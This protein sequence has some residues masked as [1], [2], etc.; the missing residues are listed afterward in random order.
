MIALLI[1][2]EIYHYHKYNHK[3]MTMNSINMRKPNNNFLKERQRVVNTINSTICQ[4]ANNRSVNNKLCFPLTIIHRTRLSTS[5][6]TSNNS[7]SKM[8]HRNNNLKDN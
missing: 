3:W 5:T 7:N 4:L 2:I 8:L 1:Y 6:I